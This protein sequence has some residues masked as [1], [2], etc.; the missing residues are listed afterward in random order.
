MGR[1]KYCSNEACGPIVGFRVQT[2]CL[3]SGY[4]YKVAEYYNPISTT[5]RDT[6]LVSKDHL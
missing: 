6:A 1:Y 5:M 3:G 4:E 2:M